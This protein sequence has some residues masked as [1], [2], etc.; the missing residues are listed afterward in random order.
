MKTDSKAYWIYGDHA[1]RA[2]LQNTQRHIY[3]LVVVDKNTGNESPS[4]S[5]PLAKLATPMERVDKAAFQKILQ[6]H[7]GPL[8]TQVVHQGIAALVAPLSSYALED[9]V[10][11]NPGPC[12]IAILDQITD[13]HNIGAVLRSAAAF[14]LAAVVMTSHHAP[15]HLGVVAKTA[16][17]G[18]E[19]VPLVTITNLARGLEMLKKEGFWCAGLDG[20]GETPLDQWEPAQRTALVLGAE[21]KGLRPLTRAHCD[22]LVRIPTQESFGSLN[23]SNAAA[24]SFYTLFSK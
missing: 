3:R 1:V 2:A 15:Q 6:T 12:R 11:L 14:Q 19:R 22:L 9:I 20:E 4:L 5:K 13:P 17:G 18:L 7:L 24:I 23:V 21:G 10:A 16:S 8:G